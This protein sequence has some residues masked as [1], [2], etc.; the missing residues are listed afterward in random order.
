MTLLGLLYIIAFLSPIIVSL[1]ACTDHPWSVWVI[2]S[3][4]G[5]GI[6]ILNIL[7]WRKS[8]L[9]FDRNSIVKVDSYRKSNAAISNI[10]I[11]GMIVWIICSVAAS[12]AIMKNFM[13]K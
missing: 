4:V 6:G 5:T 7:I 2:G 9:I 13:G 3:L 11:F 8:F 1:K 10:M 12:S